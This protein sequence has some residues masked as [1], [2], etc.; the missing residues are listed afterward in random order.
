MFNNYDLSPDIAH[1][2][3]PGTGV[4]A[5]IIG[6]QTTVTEGAGITNIAV[7]DAGVDISVYGYPVSFCGSSSLTPPAWNDGAAYSEI[8]PEAILSISEKIMDTF[9]EYGMRV[10]QEPGTYNAL[11][12]TGGDP[13]L[14]YDQNFLWSV[15]EQYGTDA[16]SGIVAHEIG[17]Q[18]VD[19]LFTGSDIHLSNWQHELCADYISGVVS[20]LNGLSPDAMHH[21]YSEYL[22]AYGGNSHPVGGLR[23]EAFD[24]GVDWASNQTNAVFSEFMLQNHYELSEMLQHDVLNAFPDSLE[25]YIYGQ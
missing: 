20:Q 14:N 24:K 10:I 21:F 17:H 1:I 23:S 15:G 3:I 5:D 13:H 7:P 11:M 6:Y 8:T 12:T 19:D 2:D 16:I 25:A 4:T 18:V 22:V 9:G